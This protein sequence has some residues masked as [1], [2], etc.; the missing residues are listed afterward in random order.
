MFVQ[1]WPQYIETEP[2]SI[3]S[4]SSYQRRANHLKQQAP[5]YLTTRGQISTNFAIDSSPPALGC[6]LLSLQIKPDPRLRKDAMLV[7]GN[8]E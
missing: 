8:D 2:A 1:S 3:P 7:A 6:L 4:E 5:A